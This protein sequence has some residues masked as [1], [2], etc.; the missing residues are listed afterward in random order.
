MQKY[1]PIVLLQLCSQPPLSVAHSSIS[2]YKSKM[3][4]LSREC[5]DVYGL[6]I[7]CVVVF[8]K[9]VSDVASAEVAAQCVVTNLCTA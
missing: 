2:T 1:D 7:A 4:T 9:T 8:V 5:C 3:R 6:T